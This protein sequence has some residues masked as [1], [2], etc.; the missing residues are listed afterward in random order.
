MHIVHISSVHS[1]QDPRIRHKQLRSILD[2]GWKATLITGDLQASDSDGVRVLPVPPGNSQ[3]W[4]RMTRTAPKAMLLALREDADVYHIHDPELLPWALLLRLKGKPVV[5]DIHEDYSAAIQH[6]PY[7]PRFLRPAI[8]GMLSCCERA[9]AAPFTKVIA[10]KCY[11]R[12]FPRGMTVLNYPDATLLGSCQAFAP[13]S[14]HI[15]YTGNLTESRGALHM[16]RLIRERPDYTLVAMGLCPAD[17][18]EAM[19]LQ[20]GPSAKAMRIYGQERHVPWRVEIRQDDLVGEA[21][22]IG[23]CKRGHRGHHRRRRDERQRKC[24]LWS[25]GHF[26]SS[27]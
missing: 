9:V 18:A 21:A 19:H 20:A 4:P 26:I 12:R 17:L 27:L 2:R 14:K 5:Y 8:S 11:S 15:L 3:R 22:G 1:S 16:A 13:G 7:I 25:I 23:L 10:E 24:G 6:K